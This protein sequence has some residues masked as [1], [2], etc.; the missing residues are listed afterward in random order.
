MFFALYPGGR[1]LP[2]MVDWQRSLC[3]REGASIV[4]RPRELLHVSIAECG[5]PKRQREPLP[6]ALAEAERHFS[7]PAF[8][9]MFDSIARFGRDGGALAAIADA[10]S[11][12][13]ARDLHTAIADAQRHAGL[14]VSR[15]AFEAHLT[16]GYGD[17]LTLDRRG[18]PPSGFRVAAVELVVSE[19]GKSRHRHLMRWG[20]S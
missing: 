6:A 18:I 20:L 5:R 8:E 12:Q 1:D 10:A 2:R 17:G 16:L 4:P 13:K 7:F 11:Q 15:G 14:F 3:R 9:M 19:T